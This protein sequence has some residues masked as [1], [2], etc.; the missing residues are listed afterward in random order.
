MFRFFI[1]FAL[2]LVSLSGGFDFEQSGHTVDQKQPQQLVAAAISPGGDKHRHMEVARD[3]C[4]SCSPCH[5]VGLVSC[6][7]PIAISSINLSVSPR[8]S[9]F[10]D[11]ADRP[12]PLRPP[13]I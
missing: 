8:R 9:A 13:I 4:H 11:S 7:L 6:G 3:Q 1:V 5:A 2:L 10:F 12:L